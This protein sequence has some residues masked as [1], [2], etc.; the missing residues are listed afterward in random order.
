MTNHAIRKKF[1]ILPILTFLTILLVACTPAAPAAVAPS[2]ESQQ[3]NTSVPG[4]VPTEIP[5]VEQVIPTDLPTPILVAT[6][7]GPDLQATD[8]ASVNLA[9]G[10]LQLVEFFRFT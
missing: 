2:V 1:L 10:S 7:R 8:P 4:Q 6:S 3:V 5:T 9:S